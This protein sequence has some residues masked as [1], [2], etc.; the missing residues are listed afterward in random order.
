MP[1]QVTDA[2]QR[3]EHF[4]RAKDDWHTLLVPAVKTSR[5]VG[6]TAS[7]DGYA[8]DRTSPATGALP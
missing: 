4:S 3:A 2:I 8:G 1:T 6:Q 7:D 5:T